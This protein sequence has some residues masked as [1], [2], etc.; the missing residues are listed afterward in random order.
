MGKASNTPEDA[1]KA[2]NGRDPVEEAL[3]FFE[4]R[5]A[6]I[7]QKPDEEFKLMDEI[8]VIQAALWTVKAAKVYRNLYE[9]AMKRI[10]RYRE[11]CARNAAYEMEHK[12]DEK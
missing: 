8:P 10:E 11:N 3:E 2:K 1:E 12:D 6:L 9:D 7:K 5:M 4:R